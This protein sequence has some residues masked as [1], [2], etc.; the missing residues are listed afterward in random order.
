MRRI[1]QSIIDEIA[2]TLLYLE[3]LA[4][5]ASFYIEEKFNFEDSTDYESFE[6]AKAHWEECLETND[7]CGWKHCGDCVNMACSCPVC[8]IEYNRERA[9]LQTFPEHVV[10]QFFSQH[11]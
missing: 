7:R 9:R 11:M 6:E 3:D 2:V 8:F 4:S 10:T 5:S 1:D